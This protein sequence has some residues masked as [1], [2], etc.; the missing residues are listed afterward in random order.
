MK[1]FFTL[2]KDWWTVKT[3]KNPNPELEQ[4]I[5]EE[6][7][8]LHEKVSLLRI[9]QNEIK[10]NRRDLRFQVIE[11]LINDVAGR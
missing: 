2:A 8:K 10:A 11:D 3:A 9:T 1:D 5:Q 7:L 6:R 4:L